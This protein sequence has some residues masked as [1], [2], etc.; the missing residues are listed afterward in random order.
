VPTFISA[1]AGESRLPLK[2]RTP[3]NVKNEDFFINGN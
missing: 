2:A 1:C 3:I